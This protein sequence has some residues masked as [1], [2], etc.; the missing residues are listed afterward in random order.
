MPFVPGHRP[1][2]EA[3]H[4][5]LR[6]SERVALILP[7]EARDPVAMLYT[8][9]APA[10][11]FATVSFTGPNGTLAPVP[12]PGW[13]QRKTTPLR[14]AVGD[15]GE[16]VVTEAGPPRLSD[17]SSHCPPPICCQAASGPGRSSTASR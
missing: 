16:A 14:F 12:V 3:A 6:S 7:G 10:D 5:G 8:L 17:W 4:P 9:S 11:V 15:D 13:E 1:A 2:D